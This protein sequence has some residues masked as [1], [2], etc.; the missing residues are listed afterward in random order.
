MAQLLFGLSKAK[1]VMMSSYSATSTAFSVVL[2]VVLTLT[3]LLLIGLI[4]GYYRSKPIVQQNILDCLDLDL[5]RTYCAFFVHGMAVVVAKM[6]HVDPF[7]SKIALLLT[8]PHQG[9]ATIA[10]KLCITIFNDLLIGILYLK[11]Y[12]L[13]TSQSFV[14]L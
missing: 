1:S 4:I 6:I 5:C 12:H 8:W 14:R 11:H 2:Y 10:S 3:H 13:Y 7:A 9:T